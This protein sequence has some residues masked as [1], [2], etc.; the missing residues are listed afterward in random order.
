MTLILVRLQ[1]P[2]VGAAS[3]AEVAVDQERSGLPGPSPVAAR[4]QVETENGGL[5][6]KGKN[7]VA[8]AGHGYRGR[9]VE[10]TPL[11]IAEE[12]LELIAQVRCG[13]WALGHGAGQGGGARE[14][15]VRVGGAQLVKD[16]RIEA[17]CRVAG[18]QIAEGDEPGVGAQ[19]SGAQLPAGGT[20]GVGCDVSE[21]LVVVVQHVHVLE[22][23][24][25]PEAELPVPGT[26][27]LGRRE[28]VALGEVRVVF[29]E[30]E[31]YFGFVQHQVEGEFLGGAARQG[32]TAGP[33]VVGE[34][35]ECADHGQAP[36]WR[37]RL[38]L[39]P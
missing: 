3:K 29:E 19:V 32:C 7:P 34:V 24:L 17:A 11:G 25:A 9:F 35:V 16:V 36:A 6:E 31:Q 5:K 28:P 37:T 8:A 23:D 14:E 21:V 22:E 18:P 20:V 26:E 15:G 27:L 1:P 2:D 13:G 30:V 10:E 12:G 4:P 39:R 33:Q 38:L